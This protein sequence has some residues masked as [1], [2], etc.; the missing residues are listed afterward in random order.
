MSQQIAELERRAGTRVVGRRPV[1]LTEA[2]TVLLQTEAEISTTMSRAAVELA[3]LDAGETGRV[4]LGAFVSAAAAIAPPALARLSTSHPG[5]DITLH[6][7]EHSEIYDTV[8]RGDV[9]LAITVDYRHAPELAPKGVHQEHLADDPIRV[10][11]PTRHPLAAAR[12]V[13]P[14]DVPSQTWIT[15]TV[16][17]GGLTSRPGSGNAESASRLNFVGQDFRTALNLVASG[18]GVAL[19]PQLALQPPLVGVAVLPMRGPELVRRLYLARLD[20][21]GVSTSVRRLEDHLRDAAAEL[22]PGPSA[23]GD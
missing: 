7:L 21:R 12:S 15:T 20:T 9:D 10:V 13:D 11:L 17:V 3:A 19:L 4:R 6:E 1:R 2:G 16:N 18:L 8:L 22:S 14:A 23:S 5:V